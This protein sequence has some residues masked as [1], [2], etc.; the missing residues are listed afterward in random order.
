MRVPSERVCRARAENS[1]GCDGMT[2]LPK[3]ERKNRGFSLLKRY[4][5]PYCRSFPPKVR[6]FNSS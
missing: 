4:P 6:R 2:L 5:K 1:E 3:K